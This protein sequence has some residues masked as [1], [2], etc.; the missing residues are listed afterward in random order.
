MV[1]HD[2][3]HETTC[4]ACVLAY[5]DHQ[6]N[7]GRAAADLSV[8]PNTLRYLLRRASELFDFDLA[9]S[10]QVLALWLALRALT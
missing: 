10:D 6:R 2:R 1:A 9:A 7:F 5:L 3:A 4:A 8:H